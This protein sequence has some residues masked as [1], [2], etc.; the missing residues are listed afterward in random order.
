MSFCKTCNKSLGSCFDDDDDDD[1]KLLAICD[2]SSE[3]TQADKELVVV[4]EAVEI[5]CKW[6]GEWSI[7]VVVVVAVVV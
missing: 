4:D 1:I 5:G 3:V 7:D 6:F 2:V